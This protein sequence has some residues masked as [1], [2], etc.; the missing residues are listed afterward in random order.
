NFYHFTLMPMFGSPNEKVSINFKKHLFTTTKSFDNL[1]FDGKQTLIDRLNFFLNNPNFYEQRGIAH[2]F[3]LL[4]YGSPGCGKTSTIKALASYT[5]RHLVEIPL[6]RIRTCDELEQAFFLNSY[7]MTNLDFSNKIIV[8]EDIDCMSHLIKKRSTSSTTSEP[9]TSTEG[10]DVVIHLEQD[11]INAGK[12]KMS[13]QSLRSL[14][15]EDQTAPKDPLTLSFLLNLIDG[16][17]EQPSRILI[18]TSNH[19]E[20]IDPALLRP[21]RIDIKLEFKK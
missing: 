16:I 20:Q 19:P 18:M 1:F 7:D 5:K 2:S 8:F 11:D 14:L 21:G 10:D 13:K 4:F 12:K 3:G 6:S 17:I 15:G 9:V